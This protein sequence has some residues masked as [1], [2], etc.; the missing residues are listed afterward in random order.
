ML[1]VTSLRMNLKSLELF[2]NL[3]S[4]AGTRLSIMMSQKTLKRRSEDMLHASE[5][6]TSLSSLPKLEAE[7]VVENQKK[8]AVEIAAEKEEEKTEEKDP[9]RTTS[10]GGATTTATG[11]PRVQNAE[12]VVG[13]VKE[14]VTAKKGAALNVEA[15]AISNVTVEAVPSAVKSP[16]LMISQE[17]AAETNAG[18]KKEEDLQ[19]T[20]E[21]L[22]MTDAADAIQSVETEEI[23]ADH[24]HQIAATVAETDATDTAAAL[25]RREEAQ[26][27]IVE[28][29]GLHLVVQD[30]TLPLVRAPPDHLGETTNVVTDAND[31][32]LVT[33]T[34]ECHQLEPIVLAA[35]RVNRANVADQK[36]TRAAPEVIQKKNKNKAT[37]ET[38]LAAIR[39]KETTK[40]KGP[41]KPW[42]ATNRIDNTQAFKRLQLRRHSVKSS[43]LTLLGS[44]HRTPV[45]KTELVPIIFTAR[46]HGEASLTPSSKRFSEN[47]RAT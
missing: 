44:S 47:A 42:R 14:T 11:R 15:E 28:E 39:D 29:V 6:T 46:E 32:H 27:I 9:L 41:I 24:T 35:E 20:A 33:V 37:L 17:D 22:I 40:R 34:M 30:H 19:A 18:A 26:N 5:E 2:V 25:M 23:E 21:A 16:D 12:I 45:V 8:C 3:H 4:K 1:A 36:G 31:G 13:A 43:R 38:E 7:E 10:A